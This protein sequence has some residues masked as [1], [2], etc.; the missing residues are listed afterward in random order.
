MIGFLVCNHQLFHGS[1]IGLVKNHSVGSVGK[2]CHVDHVATCNQAFADHHAAGS[3]QHLEGVS[4][5]SSGVDDH[6]IVGGVREGRECHRCF[7]YARGSASHNQAHEVSLAT[8]RIDF[9]NCDYT[10]FEEPNHI[11]DAGALPFDNHTTFHGP[12]DSEPAVNA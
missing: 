9:L 1:T 11:N 7:L 3:V 8:F 10:F 5:K 2:V 12:D 6:H 4:L